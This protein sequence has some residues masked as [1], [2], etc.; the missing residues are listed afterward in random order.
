MKRFHVYFYGPDANALRSTFE[1]AASRLE[2]LPKLFFELDGSFVWSPDRSQQIDGMLYDAQ[3]QI[4]YVDLQGQC[5]LESWRKLITAIVGGPSEDC[6]V[7]VI[8]TRELKILP[9]FEQSIWG[10]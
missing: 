9:A 1:Q 10:V 8:P 3:D 2:S 7:M 6:V 5:S 4:Q